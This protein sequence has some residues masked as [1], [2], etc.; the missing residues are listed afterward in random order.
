M[1]KTHFLNRVPRWPSCWKIS[2]FTSKPFNDRRETTGSGVFL[3]T[4]LS[5]EVVRT[6]PTGAH[7]IHPLE[8]GW[9]SGQWGWMIY[10][11]RS[12]L[13]LERMCPSEPAQTSPGAGGDQ[14]H[15]WRSC[16]KGTSLER[17]IIKVSEVHRSLQAPLPVGMERR[18]KS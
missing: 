6:L 7:V 16:L 18:Y 2:L 15:L 10:L 3:G 14:S 13:P 8:R 9:V 4:I 5:Q 11:L 1:N 12:E 17:A